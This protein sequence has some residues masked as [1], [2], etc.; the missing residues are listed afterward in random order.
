MWN[1]F[2]L[3]GIR[4][5]SRHTQAILKKLGDRLTLQLFIMAFAAGAAA[6]SSYCSFRSFQLSDWESQALLVPQISI[7]PDT[8]HASQIFSI[9]FNN[10]GRRVASKVKAIV[11][12]VPFDSNPLPSGYT[13]VIYYKDQTKRKLYQFSDAIDI[14]SGPTPFLY[15]EGLNGRFHI[16]ITVLYQDGNTNQ[17]V[18]NEYYRTLDLE[19]L[20]RGLYPVVIPSMWEVKTFKKVNP[21][22]S[23][24]LAIFQADSMLAA[25]F[26]TTVQP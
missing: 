21:I 14:S 5:A 13:R 16:A 24:S 23:L 20:A 22:D 26:L 2:P 19:L 8:L 12:T 25:G 11:I 4:W 17:L 1:T 7:I 6:F 18:K 10:L 15:H 9:A 3:T